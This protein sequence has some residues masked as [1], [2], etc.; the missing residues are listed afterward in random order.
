[1]YSWDWSEKSL[2]G[3]WMA[4]TALNELLAPHTKLKLIIKY[5]TAISWAWI[6][7]KS[8]R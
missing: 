3:K 2:Q 7:V 6:R 1:L 4:F 5:S 8:W